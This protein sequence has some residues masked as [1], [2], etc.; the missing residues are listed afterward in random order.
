MNRQRLR[1]ARRIA[2]IQAFR[3]EQQRQ[4]FGDAVRER[5]DADE[6]ASRATQARDALDLA[7]DDALASGGFDRYVLLGDI[8]ADAEDRRWSAATRADEAAAAENT[9]RDAWAM[10]NV[11]KRSS[12]ER[13]D[14]MHRDA[15]LGMA[16]ADTAESMEL[17]LVRQG[18]PA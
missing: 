5:L 10:A 4:R 7:R 18:S 1:L 2:D 3:E 17:W 6:L 9:E 11:R 14:A 12:G 8:A 16:A 13:S 15:A